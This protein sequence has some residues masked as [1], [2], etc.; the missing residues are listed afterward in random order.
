MTSVLYGLA[1]ALTHVF[2]A[3]GEMRETGE[4]AATAAK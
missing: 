2:F 3:A 1:A 4:A